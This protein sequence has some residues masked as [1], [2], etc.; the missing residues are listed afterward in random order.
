MF[1]GHCQGANVN[2]VKLKSTQEIPKKKSFDP[3]GNM[4]EALEEF[5]T[6]LV[7]IQ[8]TLARSSNFVVKIAQVPF[9]PVNALV[10]IFKGYHHRN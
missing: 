7:P 9:A 10:N 3:I 4:N 6:F 1:L 2:R 5:S 8:D